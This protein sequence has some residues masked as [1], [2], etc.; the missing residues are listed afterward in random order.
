MGLTL[1]QL[2]TDD[3]SNEILA[4][5]ELLK[6]LNIK[7]YI[8]VAYALNCQKETAGIIVKQ[9]ADYLLCVK[10][11]INLIKRFKS[12]NDSKQA[13]SHLMFECLLDFN[14]ILMILIEN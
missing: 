10:D 3:K 12:S 13:I 1:A 9:K 4:V 7:G 6:E 8:I 5:Q 2:C 11:A 14:M